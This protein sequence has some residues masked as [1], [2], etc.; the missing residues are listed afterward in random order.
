MKEY[1]LFKI[2]E[3]V[4]EDKTGN[5]TD[6]TLIRYFF[7]EELSSTTKNQSSKLE[8]NKISE[9]KIEKSLRKP[10]K[11]R[12]ALKQCYWDRNYTESQV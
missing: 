4:G 2:D 7:P 3:T 11:L 8:I 5:N 12:N 9:V 10:I 1:D 6:N